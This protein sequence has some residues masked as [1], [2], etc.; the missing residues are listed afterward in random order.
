M[1][2]VYVTASLPYGSG[3]AF[4]LTEIEQLRSLGHEIL[5][6]PMRPRGPMVHVSAQ[7]GK[8][9]GLPDPHVK[10]EPLLSARIARAALA[11][12]GRDSQAL[13]RAASTILAS[14]DFRILIKN[15]A[16]LPKALWLAE[17]ASGWRADH[18]HAYWAGCAA[19]IAMVAAGCCRLPWS[20]TAHRWDIQ[21]NNL[22]DL[23][24]ER[25]FFARLIAADGRRLADSVGATRLSEEGQVL[26]IGV[27]LPPAGR[28]IAFCGPSR[29]VILCPANLTAIKGHAHLLRAMRLL[30]NR[31]LDCELWLAG[32]GEL[33][34]EL[35]QTVAAANLTAH[36]RFLGQLPHQSL[37]NLYENGA[38]ACVVLASDLEGI[39]V[40]L[41]E[42]MSYSVPV[43]ATNVGGMP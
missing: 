33:R 37:L 43:V 36:V 10:T 7:L 1:R 2:I 14:R 41:M 13:V 42:A 28:S 3:E 26:H 40:S 12:I 11:Q 35:A 18:L 23:K 6:V 8:P 22:L 15:V 9:P 4:A 30:V 16:V 17:V 5:V 39:P 25:A 31:G 34:S 38:I 20:F 24:V 21:E 29:H 32:D 19:T 27:P